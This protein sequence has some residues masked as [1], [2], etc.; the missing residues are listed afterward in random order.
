MM[1][2]LMGFAVFEWYDLLCSP[3]G[4]PVSVMNFS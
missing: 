2:T 4:V 3:Y 1:F